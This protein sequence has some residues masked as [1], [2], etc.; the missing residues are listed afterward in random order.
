[1]DIDR[2]LLESCNELVSQWPLLRSITRVLV[3]DY[4]I[5]TILALLLLLLWFSGESAE[6]REQNQRAVL[7]AITAVFVANALIELL[8]LIYYRPRPFANSSLQL[9]FYRPSDSSFPS[10]AVAVA[11]SMATCVWLHNRRVAVIMYTMGFLLGLARVCAGVHYPSDI[12]GGMLAGA[13][14]AYV[15]I[16]KVS[17]VE[18]AWTA[19]IRRMRLLLLA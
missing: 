3:N 7:W 5:P 6:G 18:L 12:V 9:L 2:R 19:V 1:M 13:V 16:R 4:A 15:I 17:V 14:P 8:N 11:F 10:N